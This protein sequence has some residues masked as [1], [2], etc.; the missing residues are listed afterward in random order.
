M[1]RNWAAEPTALPIGGCIPGRECH[2]P[3]L[4][5]MGL[6]SDATNCRLITRTLLVQPDACGH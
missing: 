5:I 6:N 4:S 3:I 1:L 2:V